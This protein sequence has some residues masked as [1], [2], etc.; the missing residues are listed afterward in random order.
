MAL[1]RYLVLLLALVALSAQ[2]RDPAAVRAFRKANPCPA[3]GKTTGACPGWVVDH[4][5]PL[6]LGGPDEPLNMQWHEYRAYLEKDK[7]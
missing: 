4:T 5:I 2:A 7:V 3:T 6:C 1:M